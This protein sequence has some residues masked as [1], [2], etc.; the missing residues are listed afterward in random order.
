MFAQVWGGKADETAP[1]AAT[2]LNSTENSG[3]H[4]VHVAAMLIAAMP[5]GMIEMMNYHSF[6]E[7]ADGLGPNSLGGSQPG[8]AV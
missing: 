4:A 3:A 2:F 6:I 8:F 1:E 5:H 7:P